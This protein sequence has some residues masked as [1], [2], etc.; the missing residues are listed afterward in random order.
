MGLGINYLFNLSP[1][2]SC[3]LAHSEKFLRATQTKIFN[4]TN[5]T[6]MEIKIFFVNCINP[7]E[8]T[9]NP[10]KPMLENRDAF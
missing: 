10:P 1:I 5:E 6:K 7:N 2:L 8:I 3:I 4:H 9:I